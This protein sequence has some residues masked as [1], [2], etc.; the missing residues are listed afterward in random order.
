MQRKM[1]MVD[2]SSIHP[3]ILPI[4]NYFFIGAKVAIHAW[5]GKGHKCAFS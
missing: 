2:I 5:R 4:E 1:R 3:L